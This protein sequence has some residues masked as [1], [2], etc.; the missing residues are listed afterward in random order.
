LSYIPLVLILLYFLC[1]H[2]RFT[3]NQ[4]LTLFILNIIIIYQSKEKVFHHY[5]IPGDRY[6]NT[7]I[8]GKDTSLQFSKS[9]EQ[10]KDLYD[11]IK[12]KTN[13]FHPSCF[14]STQDD[15]EI[16]SIEKSSI[17]EEQTNISK[18][19]QGI[20]HSSDGDQQTFFSH[21]IINSE[22]LDSTKNTEK[23]ALTDALVELTREIRAISLI[24]HVPSTENTTE[25]THFW[26]QEIEESS[27]DF[28]MNNEK[29]KTT[30]INKTIPDKTEQ[31]SFE[32]LTEA[33]QEILATS[34]L[35][36]Q[37]E[38]IPDNIR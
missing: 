28:P 16:I 38:G 10:K 6:P 32:A 35:T 1:N 21:P 18:V 26:K 7:D 25:T 37:E 30:F 12:E 34:S 22:E 33:V 9:N 19:D 24:T 15:H 8:I 13:G 14:I 29:E 11:R 2:N 5:F 31:V 4:N 23:Q 36:T 27:I 20:K 3:N 17:N